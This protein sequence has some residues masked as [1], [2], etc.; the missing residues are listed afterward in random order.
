MLGNTGPCLQLG[1]YAIYRLTSA[2]SEMDAGSRSHAEHTYDH[3]YEENSSMMKSPWAVV[4]SAIVNK[5]IDQKTPCRQMLWIGG[6][7]CLAIGAMG[8]GK[9]GFAAHQMLI[10]SP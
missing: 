7:S 2:N 5:E 10:T 9:S 8:Q 3:Y 4:S 1:N 6:V